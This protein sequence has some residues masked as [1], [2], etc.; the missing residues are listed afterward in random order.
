MIIQLH[1]RKTFNF[2]DSVVCTQRDFIVQAC[3]MLQKCPQKFSGISWC[4]RLLV[5]PAAV[6][7]FSRPASRQQCVPR[8]NFHTSLS[9]TYTTLSAHQEGP[10][11]QEDVKSQEKHRWSTLQS[12]SRSV[13]RPTRAP[14]LVCCHCPLQMNR[15]PCWPPQVTR[16]HTI[17]KQKNKGWVNTLVS[18][19]S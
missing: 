4:V 12:G 18:S 17:P 5:R 19:W 6:H 15:S 16:H 11:K 7:I 2:A 9:T 14:L 8:D 1:Y 10:V 3:E 13:G